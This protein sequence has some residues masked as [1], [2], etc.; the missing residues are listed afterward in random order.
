M[1][2]DEL[3]RLLAII[4]PAALTVGA[5]LG[6]MVLRAVNRATLKAEKAEEERRAKLERLSDQVEELQRSNDTMQ[7]SNEELR[8]ELRQVRD[9]MRDREELVEDMTPII[10]WVK[11]GAEPPV[12]EVGWRINRHLERWLRK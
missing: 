3:I 12:P 5:G 11:D 10:V 9:T 2:T 8:I 6:S 7:A 4:I 1:T